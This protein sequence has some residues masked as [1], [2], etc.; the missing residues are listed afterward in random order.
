MRGSRHADSKLG[1][2]YLS[3]TTPRQLVHSLLSDRNPLL[4]CAQVLPIKR[5]L[6]QSEIRTAIAV[7]IIPAPAV[8]M[9][10]GQRPAARLS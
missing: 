2:G 6:D 5:N 1:A 4:L 7:C 10:R 3:E 8:A 9:V